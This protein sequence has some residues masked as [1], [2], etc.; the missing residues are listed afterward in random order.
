MIFLGD[1]MRKKILALAAA[2]W[3][4][5]MLLPIPAFA[6]GYVASKKSDVFHESDC[7]YAKKIKDENLIYF[8]SPEEA[9]NSGRRG[10]SK[11]NPLA[12][13]SVPAPVKA[14]PAPFT[15]SVKTPSD[16]EPEPSVETTPILVQ[17]E[18]PAIESSGGLPSS[19]V[20]LLAA[21]PV[22]WLAIGAHF[23]RKNA[24]L[25]AKLERLTKQLQSQHQPENNR[26]VK[27]Q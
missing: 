20:A 21:M 8:S 5:C 14:V 2:L 27:D 26:S 16:P 17:E 11:C 23:K 10:C 3:I 4:T 7:P 12:G 1:I 9:R 18:S 13:T 25:E 24:D 15:H 22:S 19:T 6:A